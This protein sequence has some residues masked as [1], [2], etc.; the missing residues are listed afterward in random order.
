M[1]DEGPA[2][3]ELQGPRITDYD[4]VAAGYDVR[5]RNYDYTEIRAALETFLGATP[6]HRILE[7]GCGTGFWLRAMAGRANVI[8]G[9]DRSAGMIAQAKVRGAEA[10]GSG[11]TSGALLVRAAA[12]R[13]P[14][15]D[16]TID[17]VV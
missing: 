11:G 15:G 10:P 6:L 12:E 7:A 16:A 9:L 1:S 17:R 3:S 8:V 14:F 2:L 13:L 4:S 5:Y